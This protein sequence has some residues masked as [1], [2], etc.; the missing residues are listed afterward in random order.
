[1]TFPQWPKPLVYARRHRNQ[2]AALASSGDPQLTHHTLEVI[3]CKTLIRLADVLATAPH[4][5]RRKDFNRLSTRARHG[6]GPTSSK[7]TGSFAHFDVR[8]VRACRASPKSPRRCS[9]S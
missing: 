6:S 7:K 1:L 9:A 2:N 4:R 8:Q 3:P 5:S